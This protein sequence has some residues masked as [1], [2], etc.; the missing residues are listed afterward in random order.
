VACA[1]LPALALFSCES[2]QEKSARL[3]RSGARVLA[4]GKRLVVHGRN[5]DVRVLA[6]AVVH[7][8]NGVAVAVALRNR[9]ARPL[10]RLQLAI[11]V[12]GAG[13]KSVYRNDAPGLDP[14]LVE[15]TGVPAN[16]ELWWVDDQVTAS[17]TPKSV[18]ARPGRELGRAPRALPQ[19]EVGAPRLADDPV[20]GVEA[21]GRVENR[22]AVDQRRL[23]VFCV[24][25]RGRKVVAAGRAIVARLAARHRATYHVYFVGDPRGA[26]LTIAAPPTVLE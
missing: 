24:A 6:T 17:G 15:A 7:D 10:A 20:T 2:T 25:R 18:S 12:R 5:R 11:D 4:A 26:R 13:R 9:S 22:S 1:L 23:V 14:S 21:V 8:A 16:G 3:Q 19:I